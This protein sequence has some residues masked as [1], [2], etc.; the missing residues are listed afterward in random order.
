MAGNCALWLTTVSFFVASGDVI[1]VAALCELMGDAVGA[2]SWTAVELASCW[3]GV[4]GSAAVVA[5]AAGTASCT[6]GNA[7]SGRIQYASPATDVG[8]KHVADVSPRS[9]AQSVEVATPSSQ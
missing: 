2:L 9:S 4:A 6:G 3:T 5:S 8:V 1:V 7:P